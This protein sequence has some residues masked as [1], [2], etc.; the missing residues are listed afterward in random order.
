MGAPSSKSSKKIFISSFLRLSLLSNY[1]LPSLIRISLILGQGSRKRI[2]KD[3]ETKKVDKGRL[4]R[5]EGSLGVVLP[6]RIHRERILDRRVWIVVGGRTLGHRWKLCWNFG[7]NDI[8]IPLNFLERQANFLEKL[9]S[10]S[11]DINAERGVC[12]FPLSIENSLP[13]LS[14]LQ[15]CLSCHVFYL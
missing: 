15:A 8:D 4:G 13:S 12:F 5:G 7:F 9:V 14:Q 1:P 6:R 10:F 11:T 2:K 3:K